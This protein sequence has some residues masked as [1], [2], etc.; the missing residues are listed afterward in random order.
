MLIQTEFNI[1]KKFKF[2][3]ILIVTV[4]VFVSCQN[5]DNLEIEGVST[6]LYPEISS[7][8]QEM[9]FN[10]EGMELIDFI[11]PDGSTQ[12]MFRVEGDILFTKKQIEAME[13]GGDITS[14]RYRTNNLVNTEGG[15]RT[16]SIIG[17]TGGSG[18]GLSSKERIGLQ[19]AVDNYNRLNLDIRFKLSYGANYQS[20][21]IVVYHNPNQSNLGGGTGFPS[22]GNPSKFIQIYGLDDL[23]TNVAEHVISHEIGHSVGFRHTD[24]Y[25]RKSCSQHSG[26][27]ILDVDA[28]HIPGTSTN[29]DST[30]LMLTCFNENTN[31]EFNKN[32]IIALNYLY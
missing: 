10:T 4:L 24:W 14:R 32:D 13:I 17:Y 11:L 31:G 5:D 26:G 30:S 28:V 15:I 27:V 18:F 2:F 29:Y 8:L 21:D 20:K 3:T 16:L 7:K 6:V 9:Y 22:R 19:W 1:M 23:E 12:E 25:S